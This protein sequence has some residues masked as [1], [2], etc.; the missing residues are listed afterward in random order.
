MKKGVLDEDGAVRCPKC[1]STSF[2]LKRSFKAKAA[3]IPTVGIGTLAAPKRIKCLACGELFKA[4]AELPPAPPKQEPATSLRPFVL[5]V[6]SSARPDEPRGTL[7]LARPSMQWKAAD[8]LKQLRPDLDKEGIDRLIQGTR[9]AP[10]AVLADRPM[11]EIES[12]ARAARKAGVPCKAV[13]GHDGQFWPPPP[14]DEP[15]ETATLL[16][17]RSVATK[18]VLDALSAI[19]PDLDAEQVKTLTRGERKE[20]KPVLVYRPIVE[21]ETAAAALK[22]IGVHIDLVPGSRA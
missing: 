3:L 9:W 15:T 2:R 8:I 22:R 5:P 14:S 21:V 19:R 18:I 20:W 1:R 7:V 13:Q 10:Q 12:F 6:V 11:S 16:M 17:R 4:R